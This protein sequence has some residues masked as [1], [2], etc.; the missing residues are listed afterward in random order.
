M[1]YNISVFVALIRCLCIP[2]N[3]MIDGISAC[4]VILFSSCINFFDD[5]ALMDVSVFIVVRIIFIVVIE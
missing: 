3:L 5:C 1:L 4:A 2:Y